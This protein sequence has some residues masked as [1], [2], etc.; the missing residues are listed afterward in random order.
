MR[1]RY[2][3]LCLALPL[4]VVLIIGC[5]G[6]TKSSSSG[7][8]SSNSG[9]NVVTGNIS[10]SPSSITAGSQA[11]LTWSTTNAT[12]VSID[13]GIGTV[14]GS[15]TQT[16]SP[17]QTTTYTLTATGGAQ[18]VTSTVTVTVTSPPPPPTVQFSVSPASIQTGQ[19]TTLTWST[20]NTTSVSIDQ[21]IGT[22]AASGALSVS[23]TQTTTYTLTATAGA[24]TV[25]STVT[26]TVTSPPPPP[27]V[28]FSASPSSIQGGE[29]ATLAWSTT[30]AT[31]VSIDQGIGTVAAS[32]T[33]SVSPTQSTT[34]T[35]TAIG[36]GQ[37]VTGTA[38]VTVTP[39][40]GI[41]GWKGGTQGDGLF[42]Q[43]T[44]LTPAN[45]NPTQ[46]GEV[47]KLAADG[48]I[49]A[50]PVFAR[51]VDLGANGVHD[52]LL[53]ATENDS[54]YAFDGNSTSTTPLWHRNFVV[55]AN[56]GNATCTAS[57]CVTPQADTQNVFG[58]EVGITGTPVIDPQT[59]ILYV[60]AATQQN[61]VATDTLHAIDIRTGN[62]A[63][64]GSVAISGSV[65]GTGEGSV[66]GQIAFSATNQLQRPGLAL[67]NGV[68]YLAF[69]SFDD[70]LPYHG[71]LFA[72]DP[73]T[74]QQLGAFVSTPDYNA[75]YYQGGGGSFWASGAS[76][77]FDTDGSFY[78][79]AANGSVNT[80]TGGS[81]Y[82]ET[83]LHMSFANGQ[84]GVLDWFSPFN[85]DC[86]DRTDLEVGS[87]GVAL[88]PPTE[89]GN[90]LSLAV[91]ISK[92]GRLYLLNRANLG[93]FDATTDQVVQEFMVG[94]DTCNSSTT[95][96]ASDGP[97]W[98]RL[99]GNVS[100]WNGNLYMA[101]SN[102]PIEQFSISGTA[103]DTTPVAIG[104][105]STAITY[106]RGGNTVVSSNGNTNGIVWMYDKT[107]NGDAIL[108]AYDAMDVGNELWN[109][110]MNATR[111]ALNTGGE[112][113][114]FPIIIDGEVFATS[115]RNINEYSL[116]P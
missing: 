17:T 105:G 16:V 88:L 75:D 30:N 27:T 84:F 111:D 92:E 4:L 13:Q 34:Y 10:A 67:S 42:N 53:V 49:S 114:Q 107:S 63:G 94:A 103:I 15:G 59:G 77:T 52:L 66:S 58:G 109:S 40:T 44:T 95:G 21:G 31:S 57:T 93:K 101:A 96:A 38:T 89:V 51:N 78:V 48:D 64:P 18:T 37:T 55:D 116:L 68:L 7:S 97:G 46:F 70:T 83:V 23:P 36:N 62:D 45:V 98:Q 22:V 43:E 2:P 108:H 113:F 50:Q 54:V 85:R 33:Q 110:E 8:T 56:G 112:A 32:G 86:L 5:G 29:S 1:S 24:Q 14:A 90:G 19:S 100:Y 79:A 82:A 60:V 11:T 115:G 61:G 81:D 80:D 35:L 76:P 104:V 12:S 65:A 91:A 25:T 6:G 41:L 47:R 39:L 99:Y 71:W 74:L 28:Q 102:A 3:L 87:G 20:T 26:V 72:Y 69:G 106:Y 9:S 73:T